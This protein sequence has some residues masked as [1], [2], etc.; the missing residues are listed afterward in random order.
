MKKSSAYA[1]AGVDIDAKMNALRSIRRLVRSTRTDG[2]AGD[3]GS[4]GGFFRS[5]GSESILV[6]SVDGVG[7]KLRVAHRAGRHDTIGED[8]VNHCVDDILVQGAFPLFFLDYI[9]TAK[10]DGK[11]ITDLVRGLT[12]ACKANGCALI[13]GETAE[14]PELYPEGEYDLVGTIVGAVRRKAVITGRNIREGDALIGLPSSG[15]HTNGYTL[16]RAVIFRQ[17]Q[18]EVTETFPGTRQTVGDVLLAPHKSYLRP[19][20]ALLRRVKINGMAHITGGGFPDNLPR[21]IPKDLHAVVDRD[22]WEVPPVFRFIQQEGRVDRDE[23]YRVFNMGIGMVVMVR[24]SDLDEAVATLRKAGEKPVL[25][26]RIEKG[27]G[28]VVLL[29]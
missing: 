19:V 26:G 28:P 14:L 4:F 29:K 7:T 20:Q 11:V 5:P 18:M 23:M 17:A 12:R 10:V 27:R 16:A 13:G 15:L 24:R 2:V 22:A 9:G 21:V 6:S 25:I 1:Q 8:I 3:W